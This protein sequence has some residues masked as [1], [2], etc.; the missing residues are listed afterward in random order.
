MNK[1]LLFFI[2]IVSYW[3]D[4]F[5][6]I[7]YAAEI[8]AARLGNERLVL[9]KAV[10]SNRQT[11]IVNQ[12]AN[13]RIGRL[14]ESLFTTGDISVRARAIEVSRFSSL[15]KVTGTN[16]ILPFEPE[17]SVIFSPHLNDV[18]SDVVR[19]TAYEKDERERERRRW[20]L[21]DYFILRASVSRGVSESITDTT[22]Q[23]I[24][25]GGYQFEALYNF[26]LIGPVDFGL[27][28]RA[29]YERAIQ[30][31]PALE[32]PTNRFFIMSEISY[33][34]APFDNGDFFYVS[35]AAGI[36]LSRTDVSGD[37]NQGSTLLF[38]AARVGFAK[39]IG[40]NKALLF[41]FIAE[42]LSS[43]ELTEGQI[44]QRT[45]LINLKGAI[46]LRF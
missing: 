32:I 28:F 45:T 17:Q 22:A 1:F 14:Q 15:W 13:E 18:W 27:G 44:D 34:F 10:D 26:S 33:S 41:E 31:E 30:N 11:F 9:I 35:A 21:E 6:L 42:S 4:T 19:V 29:D 46:G 39:M 40:R 3:F 2:C 25:R 12:G 36:G 23:S 37:I 43:E 20:S 38:P 16:V 7:I 5:G 24:Q 8:P